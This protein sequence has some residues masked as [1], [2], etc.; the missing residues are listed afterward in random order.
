MA[1]RD[2]TV[3]YTS[4]DVPRMG[5]SGFLRY[6]DRVWGGGWLTVQ[7]TSRDVPRMAQVTWDS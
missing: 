4:R 5:Y 2:G 6:S 3:Q 1:V 7:Y